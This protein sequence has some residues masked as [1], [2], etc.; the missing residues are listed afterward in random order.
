MNLEDMISLLEHGKI[1]RF[2]DEVENGFNVN[3]LDKDGFNLLH[4]LCYINEED[5]YIIDYLIEEGIDIDECKKC[6]VTPLMLAAYSRNT[7]YALHL[8]TKGADVNVSV[9]HGVTVLTIALMIRD[10]DLILE[11][12]KRG[13]DFNQ[14]L[15]NDT[16]VL[17]WMYLNEYS[18]LM[19]I[20]LRHGVSP[21]ETYEE[22]IR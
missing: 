6:Q 8:L 10:F 14:K 3:T 19:E 20:F 7:P 9:V 11:I 21:N 5:F 17:Y 1:K 12:F 2:K 4:N 15:F 16:P 18:M 22:K 13:Y